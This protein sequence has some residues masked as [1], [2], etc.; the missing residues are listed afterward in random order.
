MRILHIIST[1]NPAAGGPIEGVR[2]LFSYADEGYIGEAVTSDPPDAP[3]LQNLPYPVHALGPVRATFAY[4][5]RLLPWLRD[6]IHRFDGVIVN[7]LW[8]YNGLAAMLAVRGRKPYMVF[9]HGMLDPYF[10]RRY[11]LK[12]L[13]KVLYWYPVEYWV[14]RSAYRVLFTTDTEE[15]LA[16]ESFAFWKWRPQVVPYGIRA[17]Q[18]DPAKDIATFL[19]L[20]PQVRG[21]RFLIYLSRVH[22]K[23]GC[24][25]L[26][27]A[28]ADLSATDPDLQLVMA[29][30]DETGWVPELNAIAE[31]AGCADRVH[32]PGILRGPAKWG[33]FRAAEAFILPSHQ[34]NFGIAVAEALA[35]GLPVLLSDKVNIGDMLADQGCTLI[36]ADTLEGT[37]RLLERWIAMD[38]GDRLKMSEQAAECFRSRFDMLETAQ[39][40]MALFRQAHLEGRGR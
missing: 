19:E 23:K 4:N 31:R 38:P 37:R 39:T 5:K 28:F 10:K 29:G 17:P 35:A 16:Q 15:R 27:Q 2:T 12:H 11:R 13:K 36:E 34:E 32:W 9:S 8:Q 40:I 21:K 1:L 3:Y 20:V 6:N 14:L 30:P 24:D 7:G 25:L 26:L 18:T 22:P 33:A